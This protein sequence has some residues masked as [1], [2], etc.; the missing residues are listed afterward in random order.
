MICDG[1]RNSCAFT[2]CFD[3]CMPVPEYTISINFEFTT[4]P[5]YALYPAYNI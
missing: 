1:N 2:N 5:N 3:N 4:L